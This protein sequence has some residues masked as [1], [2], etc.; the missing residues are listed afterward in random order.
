MADFFSAAARDAQASFHHSRIEL[1][2]GHVD[3]LW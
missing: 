3:K 1:Y 2:P